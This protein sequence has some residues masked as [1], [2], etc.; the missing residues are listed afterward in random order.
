MANKSTELPNKDC[1]FC[2]NKLILKN[3]RDILRKNYCSK[4]CLAKAGARTVGNRFATE[5]P[6]KCVVCESYFIAKVARQIHCSKKCQGIHGNR[7]LAKRRETLD[8]TLKRLSNR[9][10]SKKHKRYLD[11]QYLKELYDC[12]NG[13]CAISGV[14]MTYEVGSGHV[15]TNISVDR[16]NSEKGY[17]KGNIQLLCRVVNQMKSNM[18]DS[19]LISWCKL[20]VERNSDAIS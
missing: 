16:I 5:T 11:F 9:Q 12:Q 4:S 10:V 8:W 7:L 1:K 20:I 14:E 19:E 3:K 13:K 6:K 15:L 17:E 18:T 2:G